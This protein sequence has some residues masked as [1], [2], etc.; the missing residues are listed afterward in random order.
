MKTVL[1]LM[2][3]ALAAIIGWELAGAR[4]RWIKLAPERVVLA[5]PGVGAGWADT[6]RRI[7]GG[8]TAIDTLTAPIIATYDSTL[9]GLYEPWYHR[10]RLSPHMLTYYILLREMARTQGAASN[11]T[12]PPETCSPA[13]VLAH[14]FGHAF[15]YR[16][17]RDGIYERWWDVD[18]ELFADQFALAMLAIRGWVPDSA[19]DP[20]LLRALR[21]RLANSYLA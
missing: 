18:G 5:L 9:A 6:L 12:H 2:I 4:T 14:E 3:I 8:P 11:W 19:A 13:M 17:R 10:V 1:I 21:A 7:V 16:I 15:Q 20:R